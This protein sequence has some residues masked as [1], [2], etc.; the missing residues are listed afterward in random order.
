MHQSIDA[1]EGQYGSGE[2]VRNEIRKTIQGSR[3]EE[4]TELLLR[5]KIPESSYQLP[6]SFLFF[7]PCRVNKEER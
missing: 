7:N 6:M 5:W 2:K 1:R 3:P 4:K